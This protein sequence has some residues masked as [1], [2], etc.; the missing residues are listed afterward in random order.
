MA[1]VPAALDD[2]GRRHR[3]RD[4]SRRR[5]TTR[6]PSSTDRDGPV[7]VTLAEEFPTTRA[8]RRSSTR[9]RQI[10]AVSRDELVNTPDT[11]TV[12]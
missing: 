8:T 3:L 2:R 9:H 1:D 12:S 7:K 10:R 5:C 6:S 11:K 4:R